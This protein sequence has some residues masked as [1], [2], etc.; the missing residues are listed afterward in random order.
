MT[1]LLKSLGAD[2]EDKGDTLVIN[3]HSP[4]VKTPNGIENNPEFKMHGGT[5]DSYLDHRVAMSL[6]CY[7][8]F[9]PETDAVYVKD[10]ECCNV[11]FPGFFDTMNSSLGTEFV[12][13]DK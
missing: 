11:S 8:L 1:E 4:F 12:S 9:L 13:A 6:A 5:V 2:I 7:G 10:A 3:G